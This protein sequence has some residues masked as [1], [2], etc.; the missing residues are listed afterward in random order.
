MSEKRMKLK[1]LEISG[2]KSYANEKNTIDFH[3]INVIIGANGAGKSN[4]I[5]FIDMLGY[6]MTKGLEEYIGI[7]GQADSFLYFGSKRTESI[8]AKLTFEN[9]S[10]ID[11][12]EFKLFYASNDKFIFGGEEITFEDLLNHRPPQRINFGAGHKESCLS[13]EAKKDKTVSVVYSILKNCRVFHFNDTSASAKVRQA[14]YIDDSHYLRSDAGNLAAFLYSL[15]NKEDYYPYYKRIIK[16]I[17]ATL[18]QFEDFVLE[19]SS[20]NRNYIKLNWKVKNSDELFGSHQLSDGS[21]RFIALTTLLLQPS[22]L[23]PKIVIL[24]EPEIGLHPHAISLLAEMAKI[25][26]ADKQI[27]ITTQSPLLLNEFSYEDVIVAEYDK[28]EN[29]SS[30]KRLP[31]NK[32]GDWLDRYSLGELWEK[33]VLGG[34]P[35]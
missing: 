10:K 31:V 20:L 3:D 14:G 35:L 17:S 29:R 30:L 25:A 8:K 12:Y 9:S 4:F 22:Q 11:T 21:L 18:P 23:S 19:S 24:D 16:Y 6:M 32:L 1:T 15:K 33:N 2:F 27:I 34:L 28:N 7:Q 13:V 26:S 5:S